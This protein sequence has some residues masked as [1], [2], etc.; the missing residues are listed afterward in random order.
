MFSSIPG[1]VIV[2]AIVG[3]VSFVIGVR[4]AKD[5]GDRAAIREIYQRLFEHFR[6]LRDSI[7]AHAPKTWADFP[8]EGGR[9]VP[10]F[11]RL[12][13]TGAAHLL[14]ASI[15]ADCEVAE[16]DALVAG[17]K[18]KQWVAETYVN[19]LRN[20]LQ[21]WTS[22]SPQYLEGRP[23]RTVR[24]GALSLFSDVKLQAIISGAQEEGLGVSIELATERGRTL[25]LFPQNFS[26]EG[27][28]SGLRQAWELAMAD[29][30][31]RD[32]RTALASAQSSIDKLLLTLSSRVRDP[33]QLF[34]SLVGSLKDLVGR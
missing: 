4:F 32:H 17:S 7:A 18:H 31:A 6:E 27:W 16:F 14:P 33:H 2:S 12:Q 22:A 8:A 15:A 26:A 28:K 21:G 1:T 5:Q 30:R 10:L 9:R 34:E 13:S 20:L 3:V 23:Y 19:E 24:A 11:R 29:D 25:R